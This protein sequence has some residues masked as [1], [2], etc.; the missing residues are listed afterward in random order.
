MRQP[1]AGQRDVDVVRQ[2]VALVDDAVVHVRGLLAVV[3]EQQLAGFRVDLRVRRHAPVD[4]EVPVP[5]LLAQRVGRERVDAIQIAALVE[6][7]QRDAAVD[8][9]V[10]AR[11]VLH[12][13]AG[14]PAPVALGQLHRL[15]QARPQ[16]LARLV[17]GQETIGADKAVAVERFSVAEPDDV[18]HA[19][20]VERVI[21]LQRRVQRV[22]GVAQIDA[23][24]VAGDL[25]LDGDQVVGVPLAGLRPPRTGSVRVVVVF[26]QGRQE[27]ADDF[28]VHV[29]DPSVALTTKLT[30]VA[31]LP[32]KFSV[33]KVFAFSTW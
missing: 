6:A 17:L 31:V 22:F 25:A 30:V 32:P 12:P 26:G 19:V 11:R 18:H 7:G 14:A 16:R 27:L 28:D 4:R 9:D 8:D 13:G 1:R 23:V 29:S 24:E 5:G 21:G 15:G 2:L 20:A 33:P 10:G 3:E